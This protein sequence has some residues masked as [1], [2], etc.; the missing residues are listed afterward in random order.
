MGKK[1]LNLYC[2]VF[3]KMRSDEKQGW[4]QRTQR[5]FFHID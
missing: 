5:G 3:Y 4:G 1:P 2:D